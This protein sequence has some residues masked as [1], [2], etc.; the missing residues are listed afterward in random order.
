MK[1]LNGNE[2][3]RGE[4]VDQVTPPQCGEVDP[5]ATSAR[6]P[7]A[8]SSSDLTLLSPTLFFFLLTDYRV[9]KL[10]PDLDLFYRPA[11]RLGVN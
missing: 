3:D 10:N 7:R 11:A 2:K 9:C 8:R 5:I 6:K 1:V 4:E